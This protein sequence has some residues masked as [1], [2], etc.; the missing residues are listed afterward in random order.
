MDLLL[1]KSDRYCTNINPKCGANTT[2]DAVDVAVEGA[3]AV[4]VEG[5]VDVHVRRIVLI[6][7][8]T[9]APSAV[10]LTAAVIYVGG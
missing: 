4:V 6:V 9:G 7:A 1:L 3:D 10:A 5:A 2:W 8:D